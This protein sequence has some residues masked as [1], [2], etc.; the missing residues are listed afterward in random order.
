MGSLITRWGFPSR[1]SS[2][3][4]Q[5]S[6]LSVATDMKIVSFDGQSVL[7]RCIDL[8]GGDDENEEEA[9]IDPMLGQSD[10]DTGKQ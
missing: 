7:T 9:G 6:F 1:R 8:V 4:S 10:P 3:V 5:R 2:K